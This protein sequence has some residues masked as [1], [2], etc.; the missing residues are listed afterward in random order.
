M[1]VMDI[2]PAPKTEQEVYRRWKNHLRSIMVSNSPFSKKIKLSSLGNP[3][4]DDQLADRSNAVVIGSV[5]YRI[6]KHIANIKPSLLG[7]GGRHST[8]RMIDTGEIIETN[9]LWHQGTVPEEYRELMPNNAEFV[10]Q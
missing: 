8:I 4:W 7:F 10:Q 2:K 1:K 5:H 6:G 9:D 3:F